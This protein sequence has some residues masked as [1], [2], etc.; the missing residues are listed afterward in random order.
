MGKVE[1]LTEEMW[2]NSI[3][4][5]I[6]GYAFMMKH[7][8]ENMKK[9]KKGSII[10]LGSISSF[11]AQPGFVPYNATKGAINQMTKCVALDCGD[12]N[13]RVNSVAPGPI[14]TAAT[15]LHAKS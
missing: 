9:N 13:I 8:M 12:Y 10:N 3:S 5:N 2:D 4:V 7:V 11:I 14:L 1:D 6:K 15:E